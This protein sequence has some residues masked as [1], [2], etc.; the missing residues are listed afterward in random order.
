MGGSVKAIRFVLTFL[1]VGILFNTP[2]G[3]VAKPLDES[4]QLFFSQFRYAVQAHDTNQLIRLTHPKSLACEP[5]EDW[6]FYYGKILDGLVRVLG[7]RQTLLGVSV[8]ELAAGEIDIAK[9]LTSGAN[10]NWPVRPEARLIIQYERQ[11]R[12]AVASLYLAKDNNDWKWIHVC[13]P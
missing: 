10:I 12:E 1:L 5:E 4:L 7:K 3:A 6:E 11:E 9:N 8:E 2:A 13:I